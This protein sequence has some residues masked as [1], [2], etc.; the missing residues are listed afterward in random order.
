MDYSPRDRVLSVNANHFFTYL[1]EHFD[2]ALMAV[3]QAKTAAVLTAV[4]VPLLA[5]VTAWIGGMLIVELLN[6][7]GE[8]LS[9]LFR[10][11]IRAG[12]V[13]TAITAAAYTPAVSTMLLDTLPNGITSVIA[14]STS[15]TV[16]APAA[17]DTMLH[18]AWVMGL[19]VYK[20]APSLSFKGLW[21]MGGAVIFWAAATVVISAAFIAFIVSHIA[22]GMLVIV[23]PIFV[24]CLLWQRTERWFSGW[25]CTSLS[26][27][28]VQVFIVT[29]LSLLIDIEST[30][31]KQMA[32]NSVASADS[33]ME[34]LHLLLEAGAVLAMV[35]FLVKFS[36]PLAQ[37]IMGGIAA[38]VSRISQM[39][40]GAMAG[41][42]TR[43]GKAA[44]GAATGGA[45]LA[46]RAQR[47]GMRAIRAAGRAP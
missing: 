35:C 41:G 5:G 36:A 11:F 29:L 31:V 22:L 28:M 25:L 21:I 18:T 9:S 17:F 20:S 30:L 1:Y 37:S 23:G 4:R 39:A 6:P 14:G 43:A 15:Q 7:G 13:L 12:L 2:V 8:A 40:H 3:V 47:A 33:A 38:D 34:Q 46:M 10:K 16:G 42:L 27:V 45:A 26:A 44:G 19:E 24:C 32:A